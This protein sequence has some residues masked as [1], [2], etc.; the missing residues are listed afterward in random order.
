VAELVRYYVEPGGEVPVVDPISIA[1]ERAD[2]IPE[3]VVVRVDA[4]GRD[5]DRGIAIVDA[6]TVV[7]PEVIVVE[8]PA[9]DVGVR[10]S[11]K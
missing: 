8:V 7:T 11:M 6:T 4:V 3:R 1:V 10:A 9:I 5:R 2:A